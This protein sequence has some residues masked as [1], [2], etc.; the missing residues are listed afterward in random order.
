MSEIIEAVRKYIPFGAK[1]SPQG[2]HSFDCPCCV[3]AGQQRPDT[4]SRGGMLF[5]PEGGFR[6]HCFNCPTVAGWEPGSELD[7]K[8]EFVLRNLGMPGDMLRKLKFKAWQMRG[9][10]EL[11]G[12]IEERPDW[13]KL[14]FDKVDMPEG[15]KTFTQ[16]VKEETVPNGALEAMEY[17]AARGAHYLTSYDYYWS[18]KP[19]LHNRVLIPFYWKNRIVGWNGRL[20]KGEGNRYYGDIPTDYLFNN[21]VMEHSERRYLI[22]TEGL[23]DALGID[24]I[25]VLGNTLSEMQIQWI[26][27]CNKEVVL[28][29]DRNEAGQRLI[30]V[31]IKER[32]SV[33]FPIWEEDIEDVGDAVG[34]YGRLYTL[35]SILENKFNDR[36]A[37]NVRRKKFS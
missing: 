28:V 12:K 24:G 36:V 25:G 8:A 20:F 17:V 32:W 6:Y 15:A 19:G 35:R 11:E 31:A 21:K 23:F 5:T 16:W 7:K 4:R 14:S 33:S 1:V 2:W 10:F 27:G 29:P 34:R 30:D 13:Q 18:S 37:I 9:R 22:V 26:N 3:V